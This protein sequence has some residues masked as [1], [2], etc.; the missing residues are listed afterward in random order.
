MYLR[1]LVDILELFKSHSHIRF[2]IEKL[3]KNSILNFTY[4][5]MKNNTFNF[6]DV[7][8]NVS[9]DGSFTTSVY[10]KVTNTGL[11]LHKLQVAHARKLQSNGGKH[12]GGQSYKIMLYLENLSR[13]AW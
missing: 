8:N 5:E 4:E 1:Y 6:I 9:V 10:T 13:R 3:E 11:S 2:F 12:S 7:K